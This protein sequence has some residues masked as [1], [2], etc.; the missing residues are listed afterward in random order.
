[1]SVMGPAYEIGVVTFQG[2]T[3]AE[4]LVAS[5]R[6]RG[7]VGTS[8]EVGIIEHHASGRYSVHSYTAEHT[9]GHHAGAGALVGALAGALLMGP[10]GLLAGLFGGGLVGASMGGAKAH[11]LELSDAFTRRLKEALPPDSSAVLVVGEPDTVEQLMGEIHSSDAVST[12]E[13]REPL[14]DAQVA[15]VQQALEKDA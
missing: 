2:S 10:F 9:R 7:A 15:A 5:L 6:E 1:M 14:T 13:L 3:A 12:M 4:S 11:D 8:N